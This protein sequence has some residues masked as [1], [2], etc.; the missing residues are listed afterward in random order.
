MKSLLIHRHDHLQTKNNP[1]AM[2]RSICVG[3]FVK[4]IYDEN[5]SDLSINAKQKKTYKVH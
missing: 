5:V 1:F 2:M 3:R 4:E